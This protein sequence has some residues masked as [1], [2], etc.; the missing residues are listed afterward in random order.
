MARTQA[1]KPLRRSLLLST[2]S[3]GAL[4]G[5]CL[6]ASAAEAQVLPTGFAPV[7]PHTATY[8]TAGTTGTVD[9]GA[10]QRTIINWNDFNIAAGHTL[11]YLYGGPTNG[12]VLNRVIGATG[13]SINGN[14]NAPSN[15]EVFLINPNGI[16][17]G[18]TASVNVGGLIASTL[19]LADA[20][21]LNGSAFNFTGTGTTGITVQSGATL[22]TTGTPGPLVLLG[23]SFDTSGVLTASGDV[24]IAAGSDISLAFAAGSPL[25]MTINQGT[26]VAGAFVAGG[27]INGRNVYLGVATRAGVVGALL[28]VTGAVTATSASA[29]DR[30]IVLAAGTS[31][32][33]ITVASGARSPPT[34]RSARRLASPTSRRGR[35]TISPAPARSPPPTSSTC[36]ARSAT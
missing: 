6:L 5:L 31:A 13:S 14:L 12:A 17:F 4:A 16:L 28:N 19:D 15:L 24:A 35:A 20:D 9:L 8:G 10:T 18:P 22:T 2:T 7:A 25:S 26:P 33:G 34:R 29:T 1:P 27:T 21:F 11:N 32:S 3:G 36:R 23:G 30:G